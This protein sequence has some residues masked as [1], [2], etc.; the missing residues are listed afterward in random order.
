[1]MIP[2]RYET[3]LFQFIISAMMSCLVS[4]TV[5][6]INLGVPGVAVMLWLKAWIIAWSIAFPAIV[7]L[8]PLARKLVKRLIIIT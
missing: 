1:M 7:V 4:G 2:A 6:F 3:I 5:T 8:S